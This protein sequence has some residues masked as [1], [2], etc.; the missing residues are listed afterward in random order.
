[1][2]SVIIIILNNF[3]FYENRAPFTLFVFSFRL[4][5]W[6]TFHKYLDIDIFDKC[7]FYARLF[8]GFKRG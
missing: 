8:N 6:V 4:F 7:Y 3:G 1:M 5:T 2:Q